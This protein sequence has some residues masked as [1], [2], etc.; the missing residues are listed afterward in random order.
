M[1]SRS[2]RLESAAHLV[3]LT[4]ARENVKA[5]QFALS[6]QVTDGDATKIDASCFWVWVWVW[7]RIWVWIWI[8]VRVRVR[9]WLGRRVV[10]GLT[11]FLAR[12]QTRA[13]DVDERRVKRPKVADDQA[14]GIIYLR[15]PV[16]DVLLLVGWLVG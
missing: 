13:S 14:D 11:L 8:W 9:V 7:V 15:A 3:A 6:T 16:S 10:V 4:S 1:S 5:T 12:N 2:A